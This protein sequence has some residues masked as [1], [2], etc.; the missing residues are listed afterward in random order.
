MMKRTSLFLVA[1]VI[2]V[3]VLRSSAAPPIEAE[4]NETPP[5][6]TFLQRLKPGRPVSFTEKDGRYEIGLLPENFRPL[7]HNVVEVGKDFV[8]VRDLVGITDT[9]IPVYSIKAIKI[10]RVGGK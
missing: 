1:V 2:A 5:T 9:V 7:G 6:A 4:R 10:L 3:T 8:V